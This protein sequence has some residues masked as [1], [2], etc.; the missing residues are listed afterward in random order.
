MKN[1][2]FERN[3]YKINQEN[4]MKSKSMKEKKYMK[5][6]EDFVCS[7]NEKKIES[8]SPGIKLRRRRRES[9]DTNCL[10][11]VM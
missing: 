3:K 2:D 7:Q 11:V 10:G 1:Q 6:V 9:V 4:E 8:S 5:K